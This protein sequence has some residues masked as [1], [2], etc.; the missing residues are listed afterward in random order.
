[1][2]THGWQY[3]TGYRYWPPLF[4]HLSQWCTSLSYPLQRTQVAGWTTVPLPH[5]PPHW[6]W[7]TCPS[8]SMA[9]THDSHTGVIQNTPA[10]T[11]Q[12]VPCC[13]CS[14]WAYVTMEH[15]HTLGQFSSYPGSTIGIVAAYVYVSLEQP[16]RIYKFILFPAYDIGHCLVHCFGI[17][18]QYGKINHSNALFECRDFSFIV[19]RFVLTS[20]A[21]F[22]SLF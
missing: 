18:M 8:S 20:L 19:N 7:T 5:E 21:V 2:T 4:R 9:Q 3:E 15:K 13:M 1:V 14:M 17:K 22:Q 11:V 16:C 12:G 6:N 10:K